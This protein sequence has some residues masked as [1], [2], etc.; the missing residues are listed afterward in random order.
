[1]AHIIEISRQNKL[2]DL[3]KI[4]NLL[5]TQEFIKEISKF[6][7]IYCLI[8]GGY[9]STTS[10]LLLN[11]LGFENVC[12]LHNK[13]YLES[14]QTKKLIQT[15]IKRTD[16]SYNE[17][18]PDLKGK[19]VGDIIRDSLNQIDAI[20]QYL[21]M[22]KKNFRDLIPCCK[23]LKKKP[24]RRWYSKN[25]NKETSVVISS[26]CPYESTNR[27]TRL[28]ELRKKDTHIRLHERH[29]KVYHAYPFRDIFSVRPFHKYLISKRIMPEHSGCTPCPIQIAYHEFNLERKE[30]KRVSKQEFELFQVKTKFFRFS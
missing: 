11:E 8:S 10:A 26:L 15:I 18:I 2:S 14:R 25:I 28:A 4:K 27:G 29:G 21:E 6:E 9:H 7:T 17:I 3:K 23:I 30:Q 1:M 13:T 22:G 12:L 24:S 5:F 20:K 19:R 16:F